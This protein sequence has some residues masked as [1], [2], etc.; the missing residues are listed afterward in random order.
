M[1]SVS[2]LSQ[3]APCGVCGTRGAGDEWNT[4]TLYIVLIVMS[5]HHVATCMA[6]YSCKAAV[7]FYMAIREGLRLYRAILRRAEQLQYTDKEYF[8]RMVRR[9]FERSRHNRDDTELQL[10]VRH[11]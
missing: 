10:Q 5:M 8:R 4:H 7:W 11:V 2:K 9:E 6:W 1:N 3:C